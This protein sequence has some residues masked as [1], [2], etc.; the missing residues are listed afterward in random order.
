MGA[1]EEG[2]TISSEPV[3]ETFCNVANGWVN[4]RTAEANDVERTVMARE[5]SV[6]RI[7]VEMIHELP[8]K[9]LVHS[10]TVHFE[11][12]LL[13]PMMETP[14]PDTTSV[15]FIVTCSSRMITVAPSNRSANAAPSNDRQ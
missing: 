7:A 11:L 5:S 8:I 6:V 14:T 15:E 1:D 13:F 10:T 9:C 3:M 12:L 2:K 4:W